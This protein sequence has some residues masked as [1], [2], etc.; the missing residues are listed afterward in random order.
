M[1]KDDDDDVPVCQA[2]PTRG[3]IEAMS[4]ANLRRGLWVDAYKQALEN[5]YKS[6][7]CAK[8]ANAIVLA[9][10]KAFPEVK[11]KA[12]KEDR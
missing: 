2:C 5:G 1:D 4:A 12:M 9:F 10:D 3:E 11:A 7:E 6:D 8:E